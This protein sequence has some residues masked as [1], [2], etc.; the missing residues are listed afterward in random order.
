FSPVSSTA[1]NQ[2]LIRASGGVGIGTTAPE[3]L[4]HVAKG[5][6]GIVAA[7]ANSIA[8][9]EKSGNGFVSLL[10]PVANEVGVL[11]GNPNNGTDG[12]I[13]YNNPSAPSG[14]QIRTGTNN[15]RVTVLANGNVGIGKTNP[16]S[17]LEV[18]GI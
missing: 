18:N 14:L 16:I 1:S 3:A 6:A 8:V 11:F 13:I 2:F 17:A 12:G 4:L 7:N 9:F 15:T 10:G 5:S